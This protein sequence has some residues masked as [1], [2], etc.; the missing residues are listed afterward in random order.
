MKF[1]AINT[2][3]R[4]SNDYPKL[5]IIMS[6]MTPVVDEAKEHHSKGFQLLAAGSYAKAR[7]QF[8]KL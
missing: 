7:E 3:V 2:N 1:S 5:E 4:Q 6:D 8:L